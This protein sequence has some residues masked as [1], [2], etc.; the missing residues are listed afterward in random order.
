MQIMFLGEGD[1]HDTN[2]DSSAVATPLAITRED[3]DPLCEYTVI[4]YSS[5]E[6]QSHSASM[7]PVTVTCCIALSFGVF[8]V[9]FLMYDHFV[10]RKSDVVADLAKRS[11]R[12]LSTLF[13]TNVRERMFADGLKEQHRGR[14]KIGEYDDGNDDLAMMGATKNLKTYLDDIGDDDDDDEEQLGY[15]GRPIADLCT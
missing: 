4:F 15:A 2:F 13:P 3:A 7:L 11:L 9:S 10:R 6:F 12:I 8:I 5:K 1:R 14:V